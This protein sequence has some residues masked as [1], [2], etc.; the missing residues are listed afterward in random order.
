MTIL[1]NPVVWSTTPYHSVRAAGLIDRR[2]ALFADRVPEVFLQE[3]AK[4][5][6]S[7]DIISKIL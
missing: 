7:A 3:F 6:N 4:I 2:L 1:P 5:R